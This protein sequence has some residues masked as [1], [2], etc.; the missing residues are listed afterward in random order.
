MSV[1][2]TTWAAVSKKASPCTS[3]AMALPAA[4]WV[5]AEKEEEEDGGTETRAME[6]TVEA[7]ASSSENMWTVA[8]RSGAGA[9]RRAVGASAKPAVVGAIIII[10]VVE[11][12]Y[13]CRGYRTD[14]KGASLEFCVLN[15]LARKKH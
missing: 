8:R 5:E 9:A 13:C 10:I 11:R 2:P 12:A 6:G 1:S 4:S 3:I 14:A 7:I 15:G